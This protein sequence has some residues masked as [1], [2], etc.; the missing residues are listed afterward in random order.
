MAATRF[1]IDKFDGI[2]NFN[3]WQVRTILRRNPLATKSLANRLVLK[4]RLYTFYMNESKHLKGY[5][6]QFFTLLNDLKNIEV[7][8]DDEDQATLLLCSLPH[9]YKSFRETLIYGRA[10]ISFEDVKG[11]LLSKDKLDN[12]FD[13]DR[14]SSVLEAS[15]KR[16]KRC[17]NCK[18]LGHVKAD[19]YKL[20]NKRAVKSNE[21]DFVGSNLAN[22]KGD[23]FL[24]VP[25]SESSKLT[26]EWILDSRCSFHMCPNRDW[27][28]TWG[29]V[30]PI[31]INIESND[32]KVSCGVLVFMK[33]KNIDSLYILEGST[34]TNETGRPSFTKESKS[35][36]L[37]W[38]QLGHRREK[39]MTLLYKR[40]SLLDAGFEK[41]GHYICGN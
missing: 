17:R 34:V 29:M 25:T 40:G 9:S 2:A 32:I 5:I 39:E 16:E 31:K 26:S 21:E 18:K 19:C 38:R 36:H 14:Q 15:K 37:K 11:H 33:G 30:H 24:L 4:H 27:F 10:N 20:R 6:S 1:D 8:I 13:S 7:Q 41:I 23:D 28:S 22:D 35:T 12:E 3:M